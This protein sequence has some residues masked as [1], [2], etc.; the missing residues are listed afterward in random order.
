MDDLIS[1]MFWDRGNVYNPLDH[2]A[3]VT[4]RWTHHWNIH[5]RWESE[6]RPMEPVEYR[7]PATQKQIREAR[8]WAIEDRMIESY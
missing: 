1:Y 8:D 3:H 5:R 2:Q 6:N 7:P 4:A